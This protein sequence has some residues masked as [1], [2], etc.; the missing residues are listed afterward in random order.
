M[1]RISLEEK[2]DLYMYTLEK[3]DTS[4]LNAPDEMIGYFIF[5]GADIY[6]ASFISE[7]NTQELLD[8]GIIDDNIYE[9][10]LLLNKIFISFRETNRV[11][12][13]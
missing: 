9:K 6:V 5:E 1:Q 10:S 11:M 13:C 4:L 2:F 3:L 7:G 8:E 12:E